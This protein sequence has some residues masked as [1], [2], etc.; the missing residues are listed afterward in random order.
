MDPYKLR[1]LVEYLRGQPSLPLHLIDADEG[2]EPV[3]AYFGLNVELDAAERR[4]LKQALVAMASEARLTEIARWVEEHPLPGL[5]ALLG[6]QV[7]PAIPGREPGMSGSVRPHRTA[8]VPTAERHA[9]PDATD[10][11]DET[12]AGSAATCP[13]RARTSCA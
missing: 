2:V 5:D 1:W 3:L 6:R 10:G 12:Q 8:D 11:E 7:A 4:E 9:E 13:S